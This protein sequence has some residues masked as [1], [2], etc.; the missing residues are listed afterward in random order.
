MTIMTMVMMSMREIPKG[1]N[2]YTQIHSSNNRTNCAYIYSNSTQPKNLYIGP[3]LSV[4]TYE[5]TDKVECV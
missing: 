1:K 3:M 5:S 2:I 4:Y